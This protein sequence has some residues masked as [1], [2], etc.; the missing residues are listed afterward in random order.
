MFLEGLV[1]LGKRFL[2]A[3]RIETGTTAVSGK[4][5]LTEEGRTMAPDVR[6][7]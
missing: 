3:Q 7:R 5:G 1:H 4:F 2:H 6:W